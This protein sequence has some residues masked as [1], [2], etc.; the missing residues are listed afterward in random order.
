MQNTQGVVF[1]SEKGGGGL[2]TLPLSLHAAE[3]AFTD[4][5]LLSDLL[6][7]RHMTPVLL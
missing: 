4:W 3:A 5:G 2:K 1:V 7:D 6:Y